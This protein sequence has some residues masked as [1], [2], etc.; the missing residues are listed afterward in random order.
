MRAIVRNPMWCHKSFKQ[1]STLFQS[2]ILNGYI[3][4]AQRTE[5]KLGRAQFQAPTSTS[6]GQKWKFKAT[7]A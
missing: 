5:P 3:R 4:N 1:S 7:L 2:A 6:Q